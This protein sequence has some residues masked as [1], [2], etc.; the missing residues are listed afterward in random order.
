L[1]LNERGAT[2]FQQGRL[3]AA[4][5]DFMAAVDVAG[6]EQEDL[7]CGQVKLLSEFVPIKACR[8]GMG[9]AG[10]VATGELASA[11]TQAPRSAPRT[12]PAHPGTAEFSVHVGARYPDSRPP[13]PNYLTSAASGQSS[14]SHLMGQASIEAR[15]FGLMN[16]KQVIILSS[17]VT[18]AVWLALTTVV[19]LIALPAVVEA[20]VN[21]LTA[22]ALT[23]GGQAASGLPA[24]AP[25]TLVGCAGSIVVAGASGSPLV[26]VEPASVTGSGALPQ[27]TGVFQ[28]FGADGKSRMRLGTGITARDDGTPDPGSVS[29]STFYPD[30]ATI[31]ARMGTMDPNHP[32]GV[33]TS[34]PSVYLKDSAGKVRF[35]ANLD[36]SGNPSI[37]LFDETGN[38]TWS[39]P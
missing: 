21:Q 12:S 34:S 17:L 6:P 13:D 28:I 29:V 8:A 27:S 9:V 5:T 22:G 26:V 1:E 23:V 30:G 16:T 25:G 15:G 38:V 7:H 37:R 33:A 11:I 10:Y 2:A 20:Q 32:T 24:C 36:D 31:L 3:E 19:F 14:E 39:A 18:S 35:L 4:L